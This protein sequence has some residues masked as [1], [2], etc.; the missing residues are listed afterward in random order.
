M[1]WRGEHFIRAPKRAVAEEPPP[2]PAKPKK[3]K[4]EW[5]PRVS[6]PRK[7]VWVGDAKKP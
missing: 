1:D 5:K 7:Y 2:K 3:P 6:A 4:S